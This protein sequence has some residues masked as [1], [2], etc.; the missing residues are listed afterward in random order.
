MIYLGVN[1]FDDQFNIVALDDDFNFL[2]KRSFK[3]NHVHRIYTWVTILKTDYHELTKWFFDELEFNQ[4]CF[5]KNAIKQFDKLH[6]VYMVNH[7]KLV[8]IANI[9]SS[10]TLFQL[11]RAIKAD[12]TFCLA[13]AEKIIDQKFIQYYLDD[14]MY[15]LF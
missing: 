12:M 5:P 11:N 4:N 2:A 13:A 14:Y 1:I 7:R 8:E 3:F 15:S 6:K 9:F 10:Y